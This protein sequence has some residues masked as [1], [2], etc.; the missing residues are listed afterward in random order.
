VGGGRALGLGPGLQCDH[1]LG[2]GSK[3]AGAWAWS[4]ATM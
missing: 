3:Y 2:S 4:W 1:V